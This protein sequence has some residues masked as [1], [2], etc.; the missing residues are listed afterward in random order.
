[1]GFLG[2]IGSLVMIPAPQVAYLGTF[3][4]SIP[5]KI[6]AAI[7]VFSAFAASFLPE[8]LGCDLPETIPSA[9]KFGTSQ[10]Y[11]SWIYDPK[12][13]KK[14]FQRKGTLG[15]NMKSVRKERKGNKEKINV[16]EI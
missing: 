5:Y 16:T 10:K 11:F 3:D 2:F 1:M 12:A 9:A 13:A 14:K 4:K 8:T 15:R 7:C 6:A